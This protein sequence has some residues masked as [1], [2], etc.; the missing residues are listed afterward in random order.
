MVRIEKAQ[1]T[2]FGKFKN[3]KLSF[4]EGFQI[5]YGANEV[6][7]STLQLFLR[8]MLYGV[9]NQRKSAGMTL[10]DRERIIPWGEKCAEGILTVSVDGKK[11]EIYRRIGKTPSG[12]KL[13]VLDAITGARLP[14]FLDVEPGE[15]LFQVPLESF[16]KT[17]WFRQGSSFPIGTDE[18]LTRRLTNLSET[19]EEEFSADSARDTLEQIRKSLRAKDKRGVPGL[20]DKLYQEKEEKIHERFMLMSQQDQRKSDQQRY[21]VAEQKLKSVQKEGEELKILLEEQKRLQ[22]TEG[23]RSKLREASRLE[24]LLKQTEESEVRQRF[25]ALSVE[26]LQEAEELKRRI[27]TLDRMMQIEYDRRGLEDKI[28]KRYQKSIIG[29]ILIAVGTVLLFL[30]LILGVVRIP[31]WHLVL[32]CG[33]AA[34]LMLEICGFIVR[35]KASQAYQELKHEQERQDKESAAIQTEYAECTQELSV[36]LAQFSCQTVDELR[37]GQ[38]DCRKAELEAESYRNAYDA[39]LN[40]EDKEQLLQLQELTEKEEHL[41]GR[42]LSEEI[43]NNQKEQMDTLRDMKELEGKL[44]YVYHGGKNPADVEA[45]ICQMEERISEAETQLKAAELA[46]KVFAAVSEERKNNF[47]PQIHTKMKRFLEML[48]SGKY[49]DV[50]VSDAYLMRIGDGI[51]HPMEAEYFSRGTYEQIYFALRLALGELIGDGTEPLFLDDFLTF[52]DDIRTQKAIKL[53]S[54]LGKMRQIFLFTCHSRVKELGQDFSAVINDLEEE[55][56]DVC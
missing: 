13:D 16:E 1:L 31:L 52:Y 4:Q 23:K 26:M 33:V 50:R 18:E 5:F 7:K 29:R 44:S 35:R 30:S 21:E 20:L 24:Q 32:G 41:L 39:L 3:K 12:D 53:L 17:F 27:E 25:G 46:I 28:K 56:E 22:Q 14:E 9:P 47:A 49:Q 40:G 6:G 15:K 48:S 11:I 8:T 43:Q 2:A 51:G 38:E 34:S 55:I 19:G 36:I 42:N 45:E 10:R 54:E 37:Q